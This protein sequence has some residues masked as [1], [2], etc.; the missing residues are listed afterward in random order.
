MGQRTSHLTW[1]IEWDG[2]LR[3]NLPSHDLNSTRRE[4]WCRSLFCYGTRATGLYV[5][6]TSN[7]ALRVQFRNVAYLSNITVPHNVWRSA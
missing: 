3:N 2:R 1:T 7:T 5:L 4:P 6:F